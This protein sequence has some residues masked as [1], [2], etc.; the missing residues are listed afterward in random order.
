LLSIAI[1]GTSIA[2]PQWPVRKSVRGIGLSDWAGYAG[3]LKQKTDYLATFYHQEPRFDVT[4]PPLEH[5]GKFDYLISSDVFEH[6]EYPPERAFDG[7]FK[8]LKSGGSLVLTVPFGNG[9][10]TVEHFPDLNIYRIVDLDGEHVLL[11][12]RRDGGIET[13]RNLVFH[14]GPGATLEMRVFCR[15]DVV[16]QL[17]KAGFMQIHIMEEN[18]LQWG[19]IH[20]VPWGLPIL[21]RAG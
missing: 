15:K 18:M 11:N 3:G 6:V 5:I 17:R 9:Q 1:H 20:N 7:A 13:H 4:A 16:A 10:E 8:V 2:L 19:I 14:G 12:K 21:A